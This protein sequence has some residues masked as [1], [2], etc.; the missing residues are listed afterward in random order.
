MLGQDTHTDY[1]K[2]ILSDTS[3]NGTF[4]NGTLVGKGNEVTVPNGSLADG[5]N[6][7]FS[8]FFREEIVTWKTLPDGP[9]S[10]AVLTFIKNRQ[11]PQ[12]TLQLNKY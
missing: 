11:Y 7:H 2:V 4:V 6:D 8:D 5:K 12:V 1:P 3:L 10:G 9:L